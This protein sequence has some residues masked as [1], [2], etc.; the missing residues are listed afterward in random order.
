MYYVNAKYDRL[1]RLLMIIEYRAFVIL[2]N[3]QFTSYLNN[4]VS[5]L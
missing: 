5:A 2:I 1:N 3:A 4:F